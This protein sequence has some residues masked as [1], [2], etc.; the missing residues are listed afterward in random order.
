VARENEKV[1]NKET[2]VMIFTLDENV[3]L[4]NPTKC[5]I[6]Q[7][8]LEARGKIVWANNLERIEEESNLNI[9]HFVDV[10]I[11]KYENDNIIE[12]SLVEGTYYINK[13]TFWIKSYHAPFAEVL[14]GL[15]TG[16]KKTLRLKF[17]K[18]IIVN[19]RELI[20][21]FPNSWKQLIVENF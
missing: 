1:G 3:L 6:N 16:R 4:I 7:D 5:Y 9:R 13:H 12:F 18:E 21:H 10:S 2:D 8:I 14:F 15:L 20:N 17:L 11:Y 19:N